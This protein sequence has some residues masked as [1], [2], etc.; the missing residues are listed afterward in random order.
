MTD[1]HP[2][3]P[4]IEAFLKDSGM[5]ATTFGQKAVHEWRLVERL[6]DGGDI[7]RRTE[8]RIRDYIAENQRQPETKRRRAA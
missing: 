3:L 8:R 6:R 1:T 2:I 5:A 7:A 4:I